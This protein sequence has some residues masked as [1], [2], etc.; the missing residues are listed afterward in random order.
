MKRT[1]AVIGASSVLLSAV[2]FADARDSIFVRLADIEQGG[3][4]AQA[5]AKSHAAQV[6]EVDERIEAIANQLQVTTRASAPVRQRVADT[7]QLWVSALNNQAGTQWERQDTTYLLGYAAP[8]AL[9]PKLVD[10]SLL[11]L[12]QSH[13]MMLGFAI[14][15]RAQLTVELAQAKA[16]VDVAA[17]KREQLIKQAKTDASV[18]EDLAHTDEA[19]HSSLSRLLR[20]ETTVDF[21]RFKGAL[22]PPLASDP[23]VL[24]GPRPTDFKDVTV[25]HTGWTWKVAVGQKVRAV[26]A[27]L[28]VFAHAFEG[29]GNMVIVDHGGGYHS[30]YA[31]LDTLAVAAG[32]RIEKGA[33][34]ATTG[35]SGS[36]EG[37]KLYFELRQNGRAIDPKEWFIR[38]P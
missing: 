25:R 11:D 3:F 6:D 29:Y 20:N 24:F 8:R 2:A 30:L 17:A 33:T 38:K 12:A 32:D 23:T 10:V 37:P 28:V 22:I 31:H 27:G 26:G 7:M 4:S 15:E 21:H 9:K 18:K 36:L 19:L 16:N 14:A 34:L 35:E 5:A 13:R 1:F